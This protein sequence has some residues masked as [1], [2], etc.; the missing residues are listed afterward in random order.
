MPYLI[1]PACGTAGCP[2]RKPCPLHA[3]RSGTHPHHNRRWYARS[4]AY[5]RIHPDCVECGNPS[6]DTDH[7]VDTQHGGTDDDENLQAMCH[8]CHSRKTSLTY[9]YGRTA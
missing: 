1:R 9:Q 4:K 6:T 3:V 7:I 8:A 2:N 5:L